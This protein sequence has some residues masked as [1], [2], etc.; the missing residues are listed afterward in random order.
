MASA[1]P[2]HRVFDFALQIQA[3]F[4]SRVCCKAATLLSLSADLLLP[5]PF[6][7]RLSACVYRIE[8]C[9]LAVPAIYQFLGEYAF[10]F[11]CNQRAQALEQ[12]GCSSIPKWDELF[13]V[14]C[15]QPALL[16]TLRGLCQQSL[17]I[18]SDKALR[19]SSRP[20]KRAELWLRE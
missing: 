18:D 8:L 4:H 2:F 13:A 3:P 12:T 5:S 20:K 19:E 17:S 6:R 11:S 7:L 15:Q 1:G 9:F 14:A 10:C 16:S